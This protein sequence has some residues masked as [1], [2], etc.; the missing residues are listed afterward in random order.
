MVRYPWWFSPAH[1]RQ[2]E[3]NQK[4]DRLLSYHEDANKTL[5]ATVAKMTDAVEGQTSVFTRWM[6][7]FSST[8]DQQTRRWVRDENKENA[9][10]L[11]Q[12]G[13]PKN[14]TDAE[15]AEWVKKVIYGD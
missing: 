9:D 4:L 7:M 12:K 10:F 6:G 13:M 5:L 1:K 2:I 8:Q 15:Q 11:V 14:L 3:L